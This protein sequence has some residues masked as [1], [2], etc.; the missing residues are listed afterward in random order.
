MEKYRGLLALNDKETSLTRSLQVVKGQFSEC[1]IKTSYGTFYG[2]LTPTQAEHE[3]LRTDNLR[4][5]QVMLG[6]A[7]KAVANG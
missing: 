4:E 6:R 2:R 7:E 1:L 3:L 5:E